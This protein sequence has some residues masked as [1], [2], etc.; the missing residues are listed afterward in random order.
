M[1][2]NDT[3][4]IRKGEI[5]IT[6]GEEP[7]FIYYLQSGSVE[8][9]SAPSEYE[10]LDST[11]IV[12]KSKRV[13]IINEKTV[14]AGLSLL[15]TEPYKKTIRA[16]EDCV[17]KKYPLREGGF[18]Q[19]VMDDPSFAAVLLTH[20]IK[21]F[22]VS[23]TD[24]KRY[25]L[26]YQNL[27]RVNDNFSLI[28]GELAD[29]LPDTLSQ[30]AGDLYRTYAQNGGD[31]PSRID[32]KFI[33]QDNSNLLKKKYT[34]PGL[35]VENLIDSNQCNF[36]KKI[37]TMD[38]QLLITMFQNDP[39]IPVYMFNCISENLVKLLDR[40]ESIHNE[41]DV[42]MD[43]LFGKDGFIAYLIDKQKF[44]LWVASGRVSDGLLKG[45]MSIANKIHQFYQEISGEKLSEKF[46]SFKKLHNYVQIVQDQPKV[47]E[48]VQRVSRIPQN[49][50]QLYKNS[51]YQIFEFGFIEKENQKNLLKL[52]SDFKKMKDP[53]SSEMDARKIR[54]QIAR[55]Y[56]DIFAKVF[57]RSQT[58]SVVPQPVKLM[59]RF[60]FFDET[61]IEPEQLTELHE[62]SMRRVEQTQTP[63]VYEDEFLTKIYN[64]DENPSINEMGLS[65]EAHLREEQKHIKGSSNIDATDNIKKI[66]YEIN[67]RI[68]TAS[69]VCSGS[70]ATSF[71]ILTSLNM[72]GSISHYFV[73]KKKLES[74]VSAL[75]DVDFSA[76]YRE[77]AVM[78]GNT[79]EL[80]KEE[81]VPYFILL[82]SFGSKTMLWQELDG[83]NR[84]TRGRI[85]VPILFMGDMMPTMA[86]T[87]ATFRWE[88]NRTIMGGM[89]A[90]PIEGGLTG[91]YFD[92][93]NTFKKNSKLSLEAKQKVV[94]RFKSIR[95]N[96][97]R[98]ADDYIHW[99]LY[100]KDGIMKLNNVVRDMFYRHIPFKKELRDRLENMPAY[101]EIAGRFRNVFNREVGNYERK[102]K[103]YQREDG[104]LPEALQK[105]MEFL[106]K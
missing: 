103:K 87:F 45:F 11:I 15:F 63:I 68:A 64:G 88:L 26:L 18:R 23:L 54:R 77:T 75:R 74:I 28:A 3:E 79:K 72:R 53:L 65:Y 94:E 27:C 5:L 21:R 62:I 61:M 29:N 59:L 91:A 16:T 10:G 55:F 8:I 84:R 58:E 47:A 33:V 98:F 71:P 17:V 4:K 90:D 35:P 41:I 14:I 40:I 7:R 100:E 85:V 12:D 69:S 25:T 106:Y 83:T 48:E 73:S 2:S 93:I 70:T 22:E 24:V 31:F 9:L 49:I 30:R 57:V 32:A 1:Q 76:F 34:F 43:Y 36:L 52:L 37:V 101:T 82:P 99:V 92:Y 89:W 56:H 38:N 78:L 42:E 44:K 39:T 19:I 13:G 50:S 86:H 95:N 51:V 97:D 20:V 102:F 60:G 80:I 46:D 67:H 96:R 6:Q 81:I 104:T 105:F 66:I